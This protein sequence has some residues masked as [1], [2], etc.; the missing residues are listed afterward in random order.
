L[1][2]NRFAVILKNHISA[3]TTRLE[4]DANEHPELNEL[5]KSHHQPNQLAAVISHRL[6]RLRAEG[7]ITEDQMID[8]NPVLLSFRPICGA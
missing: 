1:A 3:E 7:K 4:L 6:H 2:S 8:I 5:D